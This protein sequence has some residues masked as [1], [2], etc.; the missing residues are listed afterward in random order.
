MNMNYTE[1]W[2]YLGDTSTVEHGDI[3][4]IR[5]I[6]RLAQH[7]T[8]PRC[9]CYPALHILQ[10]RSHQPAAGRS[11]C[12]QVALRFEPWSL[13][14]IQQ[15]GSSLCRSSLG[16]NIQWRWLCMCC[17]H[18]QSLIWWLLPSFCSCAFSPKVRSGFPFLLQKRR[19][20]WRNKQAG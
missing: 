16:K 1:A 7:A 8:S 14:N 13:C 4:T 12:F 11:Y 3:A 6:G 15:K 10:A 2:K 19:R 17:Q 18:T 9:N 20:N 5:Y